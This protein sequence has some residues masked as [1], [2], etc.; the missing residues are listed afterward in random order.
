VG[1]RYRCGPRA[2]LTVTKLRDI[3]ARDGLTFSI[4]FFP[5]KTDEGM[6]D[7]FA[8]VQ[9]L[10]QLGPAFCSVTYGAG[11][12]TT[13]R[14]IEV[15]KRLR[16][17]EQLEVMCHL[18]VVNQPRTHVMGV[19][20]ELQASGIE[21][22]IA[23]AGDPAEGPNA[24]WVPHPEGF[25]QSRELV[26][27][28][29]GAAHD[30]SDC[31]SVAVAGFPEVHPRA[32]NRDSD[33]RY[34]KEK[35]DAGADVVITQLFF[36]NEDYYRYVEDARALGVDVPIVPGMLPIKSAAQCRRFTRMCEAKIPPRLEA[37]LDRV[38][39]DDEAAIE[40]GIEYT[41]EQ[42]QGLLEFGVPGFHF[43]SLNKSRSVAAVHENLGLGELT[44]AAA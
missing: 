10:K 34:L 36:D 24:P 8:E 29:K 23:L 31:F 19:L 9:K 6:E 39:G 17:E 43:Y 11:G 3:Y 15:V 35:V 30:W 26:T 14:T 7:L 12:G 27:L 13:E 44:A 40:M 4:E 25:T 2:G 32:E 41:T 21:N 1:R 5:P 28:V 42:C 18:T 16:H 38:E 20:R 33:L 22:V 37:L